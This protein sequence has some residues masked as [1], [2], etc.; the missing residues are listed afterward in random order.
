[1]PRAYAAT[2]GHAACTEAT[3]EL[4]ATA[5]DNR[6]AV[7]RYVFAV[8]AHSTASGECTNMP[9]YHLS[10]RLI[11]CCG[12]ARGSGRFAHGVALGGCPQSQAT[13]RWRT[14][15]LSRGEVIHPLAADLFQRTGWCADL[16]SSL[17]DRPPQ[18][19]HPPG[20][21]SGPGCAAERGHRQRHGFVTP[22]SVTSPAMRFGSCRAGTDTVDQFSGA[23]IRCW[24]EPLFRFR[25]ATERTRAGRS[26]STSRVSSSRA[27]NQGSGREPLMCFGLP[28]RTRLRASRHRGGQLEDR[29]GIAVGI[30]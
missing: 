9:A 13:A 22:R 3:I 19:L 29:D 11:P 25:T 2:R 28:S 21:E 7:P 12:R 8:A 30:R 26:S 24:N 16:P 23:S 14:V 18:S 10:S 27:L 15:Q 17:A 6:C 5:I 4:A 1:M 20:R